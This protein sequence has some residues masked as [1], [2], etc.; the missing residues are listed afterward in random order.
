MKSSSAAGAAAPATCARSWSACTAAT[1]LSIPAAS[2]PASTQRNAGSLLKK[3]NALA[4]SKSPFGGKDAPRKATDWT[5]VKPKLV[6]EIEFAGWTGDGMVRQAA[7]KGLREDKPAAEVR[8]ERPAPPT[9]S[10]ADLPRNTSHEVQ[11]RAR[12]AARDVVMGV[13][14]SKPDKPLWPA[15]GKNE[16]FTKLDLRPISRKGRPVDDRA[17]ARAGPAP[18][19]ARPTASTASG[20]SSAMPCRACRTCSRW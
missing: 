18:S 11:R 15:E 6:A 8:A 16:A 2:A 9:R 5:W 14:I 17:S 13:V 3:L 4:T 7:F 12:K 20:S 1:T 10:T 19:S